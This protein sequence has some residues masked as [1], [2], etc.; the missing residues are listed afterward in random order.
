[1]RVMSDP[2]APVK[3]FDTQP[4]QEVYDFSDDFRVIDISAHNN[5]DYDQ[6]TT[7]AE[8]LELYRE[9]SDGPIKVG[10]F[11]DELKTILT[12]DDVV[13]A[14][15]DTSVGILVAPFLVNASSLE[16]YDPF[17]LQQAY[18]DALG[19]YYYPHP[20]LAKDSE[21]V[22]QMKAVFSEF[23][24]AGYVIFTDR[25]VDD[26]GNPVDP[27][28]ALLGDGYSESALGDGE[29]RKGAE[30]FAGEV[31]FEEDQVIA[32]A[33]SIFKVHREAV[34]RGEL[35]ATVETGVELR[36]VIDGR[37]A[38]RIWELYKPPFDMLSK[39]NPML[40]GFD[41]DS[42]LE[43][44]SNPQIAKIINK[45]EG[46][47]T[48]LLFFVQ[49][50]DLCPWF[51]SKY[52]SENYPNLFK[53]GNILMFPGIVTDENMR[54]NDYSAEVIN[55]T[56]DLYAKRGSNFLVT[57]ECTETSATYIPEIVA[58]VINTTGTARINGIWDESK[59]ER[60]ALAKI[61]YSALSK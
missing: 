19:F 11:G 8:A 59:N 21:S 2:G 34:E 39:D 14:K 37:E 46:E 31:K 17:V 44:L 53:T 9:Q 24:D 47:I 20:P 38:D 7:S 30:V 52:Y 16:W 33:P 10:I 29:I 41:R 6:I 35:D 43:I 57:F 56:V 1:M 48:T 3:G 54:G 36:A 15:L 18:P 13:L 45:V 27:S 61:D 22:E 28:F 58:R 23:L 40:A 51:N 25:N 55:Y 26:Q 49:D 5:L 32:D 12:G 50:F 4:L 42:L 60:I